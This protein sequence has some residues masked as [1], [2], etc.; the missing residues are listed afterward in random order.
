M[1]GA[2]P[3]RPRIEPP[4]VDVTSRPLTI[5]ETVRK[6]RSNVLEIIP[7]LA[8]KQPMLTGVTVKRWH[9]VMEPDALEHILKEKVTS[10][11]KSPVTKRLLE[12]A[13][14]DSLFNAEG[15]HWRWQRRAAAPV[16]AYRH[17]MALAPYMT[18]AAERSAARVGEDM[19]KHGRVEMY[20]QMISATFDVIS[21][22]ALSGREV[23]DR[24]EV[25]NAIST[26]METV[27]KVSLLDVLAVPTWVPRPATVFRSRK[28]DLRPLMDKVIAARA[29][30]PSREDLLD[31]MRFAED[32]ETERTMTAAELRDNML[33]FIV[34][35]HETTALALAWATYLLALDPVS[36]DRAREEARAAI[37]TGPAQ[38]SA[39]PGLQFVGQVLEEA[40]RLYPPAAFLARIA[41]EADRL[42]GRPI[43]QGDILML[44]IYALHRHEM[45]WEDPDAFDPDRFAPEAA[46]QRS[47]YQYLPF[48]AGPRICIGMGFALMEAKLILATLLANWRFE[49]IGPAPY[50]AMN[51]TLRPRGGINLRAT[52]ID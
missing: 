51:I 21:D 30:E 11:P 23:L 32:P 46:R 3:T 5:M 27:G 9:M 10:Y 24:D 28:A 4:K 15:A 44:P 8:F 17:L 49:P 1:D 39:L 22:V 19:E 42:C 14:G 47:R 26:Y 16:F 52:P 25:S 12:P 31:L 35:G 6:A 29:N 7:S 18:S 36:Q 33:A 34:A 2:A 45:L 50:P 38:A 37:G 48:G 20:D 13:I 43:M 40:M 41:L